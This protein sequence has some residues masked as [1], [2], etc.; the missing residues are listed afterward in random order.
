VAEEATTDVPA[1]AEPAAGLEPVPAAAASR[2][3]VW[4][5]GMITEEDY[6]AEARAQGKEG[7]VVASVCIDASGRVNE[8][9]IVE[10]DDPDFIQLVLRRLKMARFRPGLDHDGHPIAVRMTIPVVFQL[11]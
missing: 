3:P 11:N 1:L 10:G 5:E 7:K 9:D 8:V 2:I 6:P 4:S